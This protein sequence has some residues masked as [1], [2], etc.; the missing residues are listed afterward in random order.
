MSRNKRVLTDDQ[1]RRLRAAPRGTISQVCRELGIN[2]NTAKNV[3]N[4]S[5]YRDVPGA[6]VQ[7]MAPADAEPPSPRIRMLARQ[8]AGLIFTLAE[9]P[10]LY[11]LLMSSRSYMRHL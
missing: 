9:H 4:G 7:Q 6:P 1:V 5:C 10:D 11:R 8:H 2:R 3:C